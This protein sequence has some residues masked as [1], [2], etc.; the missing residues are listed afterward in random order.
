MLDRINKLETEL[1]YYK[2]LQSRAF[3]DFKNKQILEERIKEQVKIER[4]SERN[5]RSF[6]QQMRREEETKNKA[7]IEETKSRKLLNDCIN[8]MAKKWDEAIMRG[9]Q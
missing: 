9:E 4:S 6:A 1:Q 2:D 7:I 8:K 5:T 3:E